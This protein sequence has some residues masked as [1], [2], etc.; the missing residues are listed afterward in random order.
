MSP[1]GRFCC[2]TANRAGDAETPAKAKTYVVEIVL[3]NGR[4]VRAPADIAADAV[5]RI[6]GALEG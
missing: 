4:M 2:K 1:P 5:K 3:G 6:I